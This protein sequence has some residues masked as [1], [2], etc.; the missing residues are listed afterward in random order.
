[1][2]TTTSPAYAIA[3]ELRQVQLEHLHEVALWRGDV[4]Y[5]E[6]WP[7][8]SAAG[9]AELAAVLR[10]IADRADATHATTTADRNLV[11]AVAFSARSDATLLGTHATL[12][13]INPS[14]GLV[15]AMLVF[16]PRYPLV[17]ADH[18]ARYHAKLRAFP[19]FVDGWC[20]RLRAAAS[21]GVVPIRHLVEGQLR[22]LDDVLAAPLSTGPLGAQRPPIE[23]DEA[24]AEAWSETLRRVLDTDVARGLRP[25]APPSPITRCRRPSRTTGPGSC[26]STPARRSTATDCGRSPA[27][28]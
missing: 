12:T 23:L 8:Y 19:D 9:T 24:G 28:I 3:D 11:E 10:A 17:T 6:R 1:M 22:L 13:A 4:T 18:G 16:L 5:L 25:C 21:A 20:E 26:T 7:D 2:T 27:S 15:A 14:E